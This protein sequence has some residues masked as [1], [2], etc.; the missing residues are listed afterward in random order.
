MNNIFTI[1]I[2]III[3]K[4]IKIVGGRCIPSVL[5]M[6]GQNIVNEITNA[7][8]Q[9]DKGENITETTIKKTNK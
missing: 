2:I 7:T 9:D 8:I 5:T 3:I 6:L 4:F 1:I